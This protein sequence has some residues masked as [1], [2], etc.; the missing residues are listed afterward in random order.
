MIESINSQLFEGT[1]RMSPKNGPHKIQVFT[2]SF[3]DIAFW[4]AILDDF[5][6]SRYQFEITTSSRNTNVRGKHEVLNREL[7]ILSTGVG[8]Y[9]I[10]CIDSDYDYLLQ[11][12]NPVSTTINKSPYIFQTY[13]YSIENYMCF[14]E[15]LHSVCTLV[16][17]NDTLD[18][19][20]ENILTEYSN[21][22]Y[23]LLLLSIWL[24][25]QGDS[26]IFTLSNLASCIAFSGKLILQNKNKWFGALRNKVDKKYQEIYVTIQKTYFAASPQDWQSELKRFE[27]ELN[28]LKF[29]RTNAYLFLKGH[30]LKN[31]FLDHLLRPICENRKNEMIKKIQTNGDNIKESIEAFKGKCHTLNDVWGTNMGFKSKCQFY[32]MLAHDLETYMATLPVS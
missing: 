30:I 32:K 18:T 23:K 1:N 9:M 14:A 22:I 15:S 16:S 8:I 3:E 2:E 27:Q 13:V 7:D 6:T 17:A 11:Y 31:T 29:T 12:S 24:A 4:R 26:Q 19:D 5:T 20:F 21:I 10:I 28:T 25:K